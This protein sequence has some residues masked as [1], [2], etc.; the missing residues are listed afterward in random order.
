MLPKSNVAKFG[1]VRQKM[2]KNL[3][4]QNENFCA[5]SANLNAKNVESQILFLA[6]NEREKSLNFYESLLDSKD[7]LD[8][9]LREIF[10]A[11]AQKE[12][13]ILA[14]FGIE[15]TLISRNA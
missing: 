2:S 8:E 1:F 10:G 6:I 5:N 9:N 7:I 11:I 3:K 13:E 12:R 15:S 14:H 4:K